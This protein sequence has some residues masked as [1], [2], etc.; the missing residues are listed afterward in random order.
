MNPTNNISASSATDDQWFATWFDSPYYH[1]LYDHRDEQEASDFID[2]LLEKYHIPPGKFVLDLACGKGRHSRYLFK[3]G[4]RVTGVDYSEQSIRYAAQFE[5]RDLEFYIHDMREMFRANYF[6]YIFNLF[7]SFG[8][9]DTE[10][11]HIKVIKNVCKGLRPKGIFVMDFLNE[12]YVRKGLVPEEKIEKNGLIFNI[13]RQIANGYI[14]KQISF[15]DKGIAMEYEEKVRAF[16]KED[17]EK[18][19]L[20]C[21]LRVVDVFGNYDLHPFEG[22][23]SPR[24]ILKAEKM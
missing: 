3:K 4:M 2:R 1:Q 15:A 21:G 8:Y 6:D 16:T 5:C 7:T 22:A 20:H 23:A 11:E 24:L 12:M 9:F 10:K 18:L 14:Q 19:F 13:R 17:L